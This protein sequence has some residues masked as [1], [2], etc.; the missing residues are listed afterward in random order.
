MRMIRSLPSTLIM[1]VHLKGHDRLEHYF[2]LS[3]S[4]EC[5]NEGVI[6]ASDTGSTDEAT[7]QPN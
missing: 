7:Q 2:D 4:Q 5:A 6:R 3:D 1:F